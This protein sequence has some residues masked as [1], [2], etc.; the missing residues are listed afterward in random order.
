MTMTS[1]EKRQFHIKE[2]ARSPRLEIRCKDGASDADLSNAVSVSFSMQKRDATSAKINDASGAFVNKTTSPNVYYE[3]G[4]TDTD[5]EGD[6]F[7]HFKVTW[8]DGTYTIFPDD[9][10]IYITVEERIGN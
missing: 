10:Y 2:G 7:G 1:R 4:A 8:G 6:Y 5:T 3:W 9:G